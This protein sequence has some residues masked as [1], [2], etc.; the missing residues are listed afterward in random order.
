MT[1]S[2]DELNEG[3][4][5]M[6]EVGGRA[7]PPEDRQ[8]R[9]LGQTEAG[10]AANAALRA[11]ARSA[12]S[13]LVYDAHNEAI[14]AFL[15]DYRA[16]VEA[17]VAYG[18]M[19]LEVRPFEMLRGD[20][21]VYV[22][23]DRDRSLAF[24]L[25][26]DGVRRLTLQPGV[27]WA[28]LLRLLEILS[29][30]YT[31]VRQYE[32]DT[33]TLLWKAGFTGVEIVAVEG[34]V[35][36]DDDEEEEGE[37]GGE[38]GANLRRAGPRVEVPNDWDRPVLP[39]APGD[40]RTL[41][42]RGFK[43]AALEA[44][45]EEVS[46]RSI[47]RL[48]VR[49][50]RDMIELVRDPTDPTGLSD[51]SGLID[52]VRV[53]LLADGQLA[54]LLEL[55][56]AIAALAEVEPEAAARELQRFGDLNAWR[57]LLASFERHEGALPA[58]LFGLAERLGG[59]P[60]PLWLELLP[61]IQS[62]GGKEALR[63]LI[64]WRMR[65]SGAGIT[66]AALGAPDEVAAEL[67]RLTSAVRPAQAPGLALALVERDHAELQ[68]QI[69]EVLS[70]MP[71]EL[72]HRVSPLRWLKSPDRAT[73][74]VALSR[75]ERAVEKGDFDALVAFV[76][77]LPS[78]AQAQAVAAGQAM[79][80][81]DAGRATERLAGWVR[82]KQL[83]DRVKGAAV[84]GVEVWAGVAGLA[85]IDG[86]Y[87]ESTI[88]WM[89]AKADPELAAHCE[90]ALAGRP[91]AEQQGPLAEGPA[92]YHAGLFSHA[93]QLSLSRQMLRFLPEGGRWKGAKDLEM[94]V[95]K[96]RSSVV[97]EAEGGTLQLDLD[98]QLHR[99][100]GPGAAPVGQALARLL[101]PGGAA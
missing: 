12:R 28:E 30:R 59:D 83:W 2:T 89:Q 14:K 86:E 92:N 31:G 64:G 38:A 40:P 63:E 57:R 100:T 3:L 11:L 77:G 43:P 35:L 68:A 80:R 72:L 82:P 90:R 16:T 29:I 21:V 47:A 58:E 66:E 42:R 94:P 51:V 10:R 13:F 69:R 50:C 93:G 62:R 39:H 36:A 75:M 19:A 61:V 78:K 53:L 67:L 99:F 73:R 6:P 44:L 48:T 55:V 27:P 25:F 56:E 1:E 70:K 85:L 9:A 18:P 46:S 41:R 37:G 65:R 34:F 96:I 5:A 81:I 88:R 98:G 7:E 60:L 84:E 20:E 91:K 4:G 87:A 17:A 22:E 24:R 45:R 74:V 33:V 76:E 101:R 79:A 23:R 54:G 71:T 26:R 8:E 49:L 15:A 95:F 32:D 52:E 97:R